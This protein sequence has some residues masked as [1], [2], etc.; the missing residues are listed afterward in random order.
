M[1][2]ITNPNWQFIDPDGSFQLENPH[3]HSYLY[4]PLVNEAGMMSAITPNLNGDVKTDQ[5]TFLTPPVSVEDLHT[6]RAARNFWIYTPKNSAWSVTGNSASQIAQQFSDEGADYV[7]L[8]AGFLWH[9]LT[10]TNQ[11]TGLQAETI[12]F[13]PSNEDRVELMKVTLTNIAEGPITITPTAAIPMYG[14]SADNLRDHRHVSSLLHRIRCTEN[15][16]LVRP[17]LSFDERGHLPNDLTYAVLGVQGDGGKPTG[18]TPVLEDFIGE[19]GTLDWPET[20]VKSLPHTCVAGQTYEGYEAIGG[21][22]FEDT[23]LQPGESKSYIIILAIL[24]IDQRTESLSDKYGTEAAF[25]T[26]LAKTKGYWQKKLETFAIKTGSERFDLW[27]R[28]VAIQPTLRRLFG[29]SFLPYHDYGR[30]PRLARSMAR[31]PGLTAHRK[32]RCQ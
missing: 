5:N 12:N 15:G 31:H 32:R 20:V 23:I 16:V 21:I 4:F 17:T 19:G 22:H 26:W 7:T 6:S 10:R 25:D 24:E 2:K 8:E 28:W 11:H 13:V 9:K 14:R 1:T 27:T 30:G 29:N 3:Q 18:F